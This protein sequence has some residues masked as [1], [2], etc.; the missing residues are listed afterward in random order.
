MA[1]A[2]TPKSGKQPVGE[3]FFKLQSRSQ[4]KRF[5]QFVFEGSRPSMIHGLLTTSGFAATSFCNKPE[6]VRPTHLPSQLRRR[7]ICPNYIGLSRKLTPRF[8]YALGRT[9]SISKAMRQY[10]SPSAQRPSVLRQ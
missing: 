3:L 10:R 8:R 1:V 5:L 7:P 9:Q 6:L 4:C 2:K